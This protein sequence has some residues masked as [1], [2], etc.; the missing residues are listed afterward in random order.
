MS[1]YVTGGGG[2]LSAGIT[3]ER[4]HLDI[5]MLPLTR[6]SGKLWPNFLGRPRC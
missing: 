3:P 4:V 5:I 6:P 2:E 1:P